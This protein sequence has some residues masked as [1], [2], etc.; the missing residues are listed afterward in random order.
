MGIHSLDKDCSVLVQDGDGRVQPFWISA[1][2]YRFIK[3]ISKIACEQGENDGEYFNCSGELSNMV[4]ATYIDQG[5]DEAAERI[6]NTE[7][8][9]IGSGGGG[10]GS[11]VNWDFSG[12][13]DF[14][15]TLS[16]NIAT[17]IIIIV[18]VAA[19]AG[20]IILI[21]VIYCVCKHKKEI[22]FVAGAAVGGP[23][24]AQIA[25]QAVSNKM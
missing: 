12:I 22:A 13:S 15:K 2:S 10:S 7:E 9:D 5:T 1:G 23:V 3:N 21:I 19:I 24:G 18:I 16:E 17:I 8:G 14:F 11:S 6:I 25:S 4:D 20:G